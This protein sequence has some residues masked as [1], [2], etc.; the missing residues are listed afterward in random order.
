MLGVVDTVIDGHPDW[1]RVE[2]E[3]ETLYVWMFKWDK[4]LVYVGTLD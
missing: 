3:L 2:I 4:N 1:W